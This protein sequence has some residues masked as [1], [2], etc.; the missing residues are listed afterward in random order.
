[1]EIERNVG[2]VPSWDGCRSEVSRTREGRYESVREG[3]LCHFGEVLSGAESYL[4]EY[5][6]S[7]VTLRIHHPMFRQSKVVLK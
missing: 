7:L 2:V 3:P 1:M 6:G 5:M 4:N